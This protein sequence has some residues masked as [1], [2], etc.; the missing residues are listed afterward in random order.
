M[1][2]QRDGD[3]GDTPRERKEDL[4]LLPQELGHH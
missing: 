2:G 4:A 1:S 3:I